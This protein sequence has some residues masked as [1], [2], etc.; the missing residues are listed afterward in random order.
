MLDFNARRP[1]PPE[2]S[3][4]GP[5]RLAVLP[6]RNASPDTAQSEY[7]R[8]GFEDE[9]D[10]RLGRFSYAHLRVLTKGSTSQYRDTAKSPAQIGNELGARYLLEGTVAFAPERTRVTAELVDTADQT[11]LWSREYV[12]PSDGLM[13]VQEEIVDSVGRAIHVDYP[14]GQPEDRSLGETS[15]SA[16][17]DEYLLGRYEFE[18]QTVPTLR[19]ALQHF[20][21][22]TTLDPEYA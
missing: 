6:F 11:I 5:V 7:L 16:A 19:R 14:G 21:K 4:A 12:R 20:T 10:R 3:P 8:N 17:H 18:Q 1:K 13:A 22:A 9:L 15:S 2:D